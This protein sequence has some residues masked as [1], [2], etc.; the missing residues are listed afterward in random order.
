MS[1]SFKVSVRG[2]KKMF[3]RILALD[4]VNLEIAEGEGVVLLGPNGSGKSTLAKI[5]MGLLSP[6]EGKVYRN[7]DKI[8]YVPEILPTLDPGMRV[9]DLLALY[10]SIFDINLKYA[11]KL[12]VEK[13]LNRKYRSL[14]KGM[15]KKVLI[16]LAL[17]LEPDLLILDEAFMGLDPPSQIV[18][19]EILRGK[20]YLLITHL[21]QLIPKNCTRIVRLEQGKVVEVRPCVE[22]A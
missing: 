16:S 13:F 7:F 3:G 5:I 10:T 21:I 12:G 15:K 2:V 8:G 17:G 4:G 20:T 9:F 22:I 11:K 1:G 19:N 18:L 14:S 6:D